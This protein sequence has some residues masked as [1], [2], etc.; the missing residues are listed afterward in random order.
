MTQLEL[1]PST[2]DKRT[3]NNVVRHEYR[4]LSREEKADIK[5]LKD[6]ASDFIMTCRELQTNAK[7][8]SRKREFSLAITHMEDAVMRAV[9]GITE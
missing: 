6:M 9:R 2:D 8:Q 1:F 5:I 7:E 3:E 4:L